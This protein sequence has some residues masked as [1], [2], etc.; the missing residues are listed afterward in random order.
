MIN[1]KNILR[2][3]SNELIERMEKR[4]VTHRQV[5]LGSRAM[6]HN[7]MSYMQGDNFPNP[8]TLALIAEYLDCTVDDL[9]GYEDSGFVKKRKTD[10][11]FMKYPSEDS[12]TPYLRDQIVHKMN[13]QK[14]TEEELARRSG[15]G[16]NTIKR[17]L[18]LHSGMP[19][20]SYLLCICD[21][22]ECTPS[23][24]MGY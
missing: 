6:P 16:V 12:F 18:C 14:F 22:L 17:Y 23:E 11:V 3:F 4:G 15:V 7:I 19:Q 21:A 20:M 1:T 10:S 24:L 5:A 13:E 9:L 8:W 2:Q